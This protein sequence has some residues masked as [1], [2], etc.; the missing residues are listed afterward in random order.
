MHKV[1]S[2]LITSIVYLVMIFGAQGQKKLMEA[3]SFQL[4]A[5]A[6]DAELNEAF[7]LIGAMPEYPGGVDSLYAYLQNTISY[8]LTAKNENIQGLVMTSFVVDTSGQV[9]LVK[10][11]K[12]VRGDVDSVCLNAISDMPIW[13]PGSLYE[14]PVRVQFVLPVNFVLNTDKL[15]TFQGLTLNAGTAE[16]VPFVLIYLEGMGKKEMKY[17]D[18]DGVFKFNDL[19]S[20]EYRLHGQ[21]FNFSPFDTTIFVDENISVFIIPQLRDSSKGEY[22]L[23]PAHFTAQGAMEDIENDTMRIVI[24]NS[25]TYEYTIFKA[26]SIF[27]V[28]Y[29]VDFTFYDCENHSDSD[30][31]A[32]NR[33]IF[34]HL[35][36][37]YGKKWRKEIRKD[38]FGLKR[39]K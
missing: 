10:T 32:Y 20:G 15:F 1:H 34:N 27:E 29:N 18:F 21:Y 31:E 23:F 26:D 17:S 36:K 11:I 37:T 2:V 24:R 28:K 9:T 30:F 6:L 7:C 4:Q 14:K 8:P 16:A 3:G 33:V 38:V 12:G 13:K 19:Q 39:R 35:D 22:Y 25:F 5:S